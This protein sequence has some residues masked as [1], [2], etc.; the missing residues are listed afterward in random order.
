MTKI[1]I[2]LIVSIVITI[3]GAA[4]YIGELQGTLSALENN[5]RIGS[6]LDGRVKALENDKNYQSF[7]TKVKEAEERIESLKKTS[8]NLRNL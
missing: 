8:V 6:E 2:G 4:K 1:E 5:V 3:I 7:L